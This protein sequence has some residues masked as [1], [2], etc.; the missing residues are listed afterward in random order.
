MSEENINKGINLRV[1]V[2]C[3]ALATT[4]W[5]LRAM[6]NEYSA[7]ISFPFE[8]KADS[9]TYVSLEEPPTKIQLNVTGYGWTIF[10]RSIGMGVETLHYNV[11]NALNPRRIRSAEVFTVVGDEVKEMKVN[12]VK[13]E[14][15]D[16][17]D[18]R[19]KKEVT[20]IPKWVGEAV[21]F[22]K[23]LN[24][25][26]ETILVE[27]PQQEIS[28]LRDELEVEITDADLVEDQSIGVDLESFFPEKVVL[29]ETEATIQYKLYHYTNKAIKVPVVYKNFPARL[30]R[31]LSKREVTVA[32]TLEK[33][34]VSQVT[35]KNFRVIADYDQ[36]SG[37]RIPLS[38][39]MKRGTPVKTS[40]LTTNYLSLKDL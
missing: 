1:V 16:L 21:K 39:T 18:I 40:K 9:S 38:L 15:N 6:D 19:I 23:G 8:L 4:F 27:G 22:K 10:K 25:F 14:L 26:P 35:I 5:F 37:K 7:T 24:I 30:R 32:I 34:N 31:K 36:R 12:F 29:N 2:I 3:V 33:E 28:L 11:A 20:L 13:T 17:Y